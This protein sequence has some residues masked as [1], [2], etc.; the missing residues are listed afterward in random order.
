MK[1]KYV[2]GALAIVATSLISCQQKN[3]TMQAPDVEK[4]PKE[5]TIHDDTRVD[6]YYWLNEREN[7]EVIAY[8]EAENKYT[9]NF[10][11]DTQDLQDELFKEMTARIKQDDQSVPY[12]KNG[13]EYYTRFEKGAEHPF[14][15]R[16]SENGKG[17]EE[18]MLNVN[19]MAKDYAYFQVG[20]LS[21]SHNNRYLAYS[22]DT[23]S[24]RQY[25]IH[26]KDL[27]TGEI[28]EDQIPNTTGG[29]TWA[30]DNLT[31]FY[32]MKDE[33]LRPYRIYK[34]TVGS[35]TKNDALIYEENDATFNS[36]ITKSKSDKY[37]FIVSESTLSTEYRYIAADQPN[38]TFQV[39]QPRQEK[40]EYSVSHHGDYFYILTNMDAQNFRV[41]RTPV[42]KTTKENWKEVV[43]HHTETLIEGIDLFNQFM[44]IDQRTGGLTEIR[45]I[46]WDGKYDYLIPFEEAAYT[47]YSS[48]NPD[49]T[50]TKIRY[51]YTSM[52]TPSQKIAMDYRTKEKEILKQTEVLGGYDATQYESQRFFA[53][54][55]DGTKVP[56][57]IVYKKG[58]KQDGQA[59]MLLYA[60]GS[61]GSS[62]D[63]YF[64]YSRISLLDRGFAFALAH[65]RGGQEM[66]RQWYEDGKF[67]KKK[68]TFTDYID[69]AE[70]MIEHKY[71]SA[72]KLFAEG[73]SAGGLLMG[74]VVNMKP[75]LFKGVI[76]AV[77]FVDVV[78]TMLDESI[79]LTTGEFSEWGNPKDKVYYDYMLS[80]SPYD[81]VKAH[82]YPAM[83][84]TTGLHDS[85]VQYW[86]PAKWVAK[87][88]DMKTDDKPLLLLTNMDFG[89]SGASGRFQPYK[90]IAKEFA[91]M[92]K[93]LEE[94]E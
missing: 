74:A 43:A 17:K 21:V 72:E 27:K 83:L 4:K 58:W 5:L 48:Y 52:T 18:I 15:C 25:T 35:D 65:I 84:V 16:K 10:F 75:E 78:T 29:I 7:P 68:N 24:R 70:H 28:F 85:Q 55:D 44:V 1:T 90:E 45:I 89:H 87:L 36:Y 47:A 69:V 34:H 42:T 77:P 2:F 94:K 8:L 91:F 61:Y 9:D 49:F 40:L 57:S 86:E 30:N 37:I 46:S 56:V 50:T 39:L 14:Y 62:M 54:A 71:T 92:F 41:M 23:V 32:T 82:D 81:N 76:A 53:T 64:S 67:L 80:Y 3:N 38:A 22:V 20:G 26:V 19:N 88:R 13:Y 59:P 66:G 11:E 31:L 51:G 79:P 73:G 6:N 33:A 63:P 12:T 93:L 60:Y